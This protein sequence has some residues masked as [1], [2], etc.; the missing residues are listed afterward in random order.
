M[1]FFSQTS[2]WGDC[3]TNLFTRAVLEIA[4]CWVPGN[5]LM[6][7]ISFWTEKPVNSSLILQAIIASL[8][9]KE[10]SQAIYWHISTPE[11][12]FKL[13]TRIWTCPWSLA[14]QGSAETCEGQVASC[15]LKAVWHSFPNIHD[16][17]V[18]LVLTC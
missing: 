10:G 2:T 18:F 7:Q 9:R 1:K 3:S 11:C 5:I 12:S 8:L 17:D 6:L 16:E 13:A 14:S 15:H 4:V